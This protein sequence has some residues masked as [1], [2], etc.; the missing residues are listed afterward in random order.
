M[1]ALYAIAA[2]ALV[3][4]VV[5]AI[6]TRTSGNVVATSATDLSIAVLP[7]ANVSGSASDAAFVDGLSEELIGVLAKIHRL[8]VVARTSAFAFR[9]SNLDVRRIADSLHVANV[10]EGS[11]QKVGER[12][13][14]QVRLIDG[15]DPRPPDPGEQGGMR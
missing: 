6:S 12:L 3:A 7:L 13:R 1:T 8:R 2:L 5:Y 11:V 9:N 10:L 14:V 4:V 15:H